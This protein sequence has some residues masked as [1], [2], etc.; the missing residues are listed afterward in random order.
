L[1]ARTVA[2]KEALFSSSLPAYVLDAVIRQFGHP[3]APTV[4]RLEMAIFG[5]G[6]GVSQ[7]RLLP[8]F[9]HARVNYAQAFPHLYP[10]LEGTYANWS[11]AVHG[12]KRP[13]DI[14]LCAP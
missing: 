11:W 3:Q 8:W 14:S 2:F 13:R 7:R 4:L 1:R 9:L 6:K 5:A 12:R 10:R